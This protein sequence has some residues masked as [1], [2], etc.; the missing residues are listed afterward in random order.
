MKLLKLQF[1]LLDYTFFEVVPMLLLHRLFWAAIQ[2][3]NIYS[4]EEKKTLLLLVWIGLLSTKIWDEITNGS[5]VWHENL[6][7]Q[8]LMIYPQSSRK[9]FVNFLIT[10]DLEW[11][12]NFFLNDSWIFQSGSVFQSWKISSNNLF[13]QR[14]LKAT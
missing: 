5:F 10:C 2:K 14:S 9:N 13:I 7:L 6:L 1:V 8:A 11:N 3:N 4:E 12:T